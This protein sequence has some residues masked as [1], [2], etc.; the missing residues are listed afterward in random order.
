MADIEIK[1]AEE[2]HV[3]EE[4]KVTRSSGNVFADL[5]LPDADEALAKADLA[6]TIN[7]TIK[8]RGL[9]QEEAARI[10]E[11]DQPNVSR[12]SRGR[13]S[14]FSLDRLFHLLTLLDLNVEV[15]V[16]KKSEDQAHGRVM[17]RAVA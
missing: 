1:A 11:I 16:T 14:G 12:L 8:A 15:N 17:V 4:I 9:T 3:S 7:K 2:I 10:L 5:G 6:Y 13:L